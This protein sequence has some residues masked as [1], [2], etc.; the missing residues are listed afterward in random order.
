MRKCIRCNSTMVGGC[1]IKVKGVGI[2]TCERYDLPGVS[3]VYARERQLIQKIFLLA[4]IVKAGNT[5]QPP[6]APNTNN[7]HYCTLTL[8]FTIK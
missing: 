6:I 5:I 2:Y 7:Y 8:I 4:G 3:P 1:G